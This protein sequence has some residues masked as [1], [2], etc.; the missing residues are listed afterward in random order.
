MKRTVPFI[1]LLIITLLAFSGTTV[2][3]DAPRP[4]VIGMGTQPDSMLPDY[5]RTALA[6]FA[7]E[8]VYTALV[9]FDDAGNPVPDLAESWSLSDDNL[10]WTVTLRQDVLWHDGE[11]FTADDVKFNFEFPAD[12]DFTGATYDPS[13]A[14]AAERKAGEAD[15]VSGVQVIDDYTVSITTIEPNALFLQTIATK[16][17]VPQHAFEGIPVAEYASSELARLPIGTGPYRVTDW[18]PDESVTFEAFPEYY[19]EPAS[20]QTIIWRVIPEPATQVTELITGGVDILPAVSADDVFSLEGEDGIVVESVTGAFSTYLMLNH[21]LSVFSDLRMR[22]AI[23]HAVDAQ[24]ILEVISGGIGTAATSHV[25]PEVPEFNTELMGYAY[26]PARAQALLDE[27]GWVDADGDGVRE[28]NGVEGVADGTRLALTITT[29]SS[30]VWT[31]RALVVQQSLNDIGFEIR[32]NPVDFNAI[33]AEYFTPN[34]EYDMLLSGWSNLLVPTLSDLRGNF[35][36]GESNTAVI[37]WSNAELDGL[38]DTIPT[39]FDDEE[40]ISTFWRVQEIIEAELPVVYLT[41]EAANFAYRDR[42]ALPEI[43]SIVELFE[44]IPEW[45]FA[46]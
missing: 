21:D 29:F 9:A 42:L 19:G 17:L 35:R 46:G 8:N 2:A 6:G 40:R 16:Q 14:G 24:A 4:L 33:F 30:P 15:E 36:S 27:L 10:T 34:S 37:R 28:A 38:I 11:P 31:N 43:G 20:I 3:Q 23:A 45:E 7:I 1:S 12:P 39:I 5:A 25:F 44:T 18:Q 13:I 41:R 32:V 22:Q 26:D